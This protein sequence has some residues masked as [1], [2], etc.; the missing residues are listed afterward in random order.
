[1]R[2]RSDDETGGA[3]AGS[4]S[5]QPPRLLLQPR[6]AETGSAAVDRLVDSPSPMARRGAAPP[7][8]PEVRH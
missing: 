5:L 8:G 1:M 7:A 2:R 4:A 6:E 3:S